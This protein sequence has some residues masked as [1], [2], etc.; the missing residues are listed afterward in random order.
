MKY[1]LTSFAAEIV[2]MKT[3]RYVWMEETKDLTLTC[4]AKG[5]PAPVITW[6]KDN[7]VIQSASRTLQ[8]QDVRLNQSGIYECW[9]NNTHGADARQFDLFV[10]S[11]Y[12]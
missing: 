5:Y 2:D 11:Q 10:T 3:N 7:E 8:L 6:V 1:F 12:T 4:D 9:A